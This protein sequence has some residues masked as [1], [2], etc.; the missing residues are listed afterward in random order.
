MTMQLTHYGQDILRKKT[1]RIDQV[2]DEH[3]ELIDE[4]FETMY[5]EEGI[6]LAAN[7]VGI[8]LALAT[9]DISAIDEEVEPFVII[10]PEILESEG[11]E[12]MD[13]GCLSIPGVRE[14]VKRACS[15][16]VRY[17]TP[18]GETVEREAEN[19]LARVIQHETDHLNGTF[20]VDRLSPLKRRLI[21]RQLETISR[22]GFPA[23]EE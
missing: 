16:V 7:Q 2:T 12:S 23:D 13:E 18:E 21:N 8:D 22:E 9:I 15:L 20:F 1:A 4:M 14:S 17:M 6:G 10:N 11:S 5:R 3:L 19:M